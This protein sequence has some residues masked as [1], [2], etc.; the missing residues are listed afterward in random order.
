[1]TRPLTLDTRWH[2]LIAGVHQRENRLLLVLLAG[3]VVDLAGL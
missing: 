3:K 2:E 1:M